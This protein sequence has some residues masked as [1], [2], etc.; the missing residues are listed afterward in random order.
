V[1]RY[2]D[3]A[4]TSFSGILKIASAHKKHSQAIFEA[5]GTLIFHH[6]LADPAFTS[7][8]GILKIASAHRKH[9]QAIWAQEYYFIY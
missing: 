4:F 6:P 5:T 8:S 2:L 9:S 7:F 1:H 3:P